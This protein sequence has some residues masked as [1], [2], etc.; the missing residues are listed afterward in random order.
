M[1]DELDSMK[2]QL[3][4][5]RKS[6]T[7]VRLELAKAKRKIY[8]LTTEAAVWKAEYLRQVQFAKYFVLFFVWCLLLFVFFAVNC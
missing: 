5:T 6:E 1:Q 8:E 4:K 7:G 3:S 2:E